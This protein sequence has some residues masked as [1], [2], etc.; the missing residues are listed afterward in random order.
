M[1]TLVHK[2]FEA[3]CTGNL[4]NLTDEVIC[5][6]LSHFAQSLNPEIPSYTIRKYFLCSKQPITAQGSMISNGHQAGSQASALMESYPMAA[7]WLW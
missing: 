6:Q 7:T 4:A 2:G 3:V 1:H 5:R